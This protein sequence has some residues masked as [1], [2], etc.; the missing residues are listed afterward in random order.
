MNGKKSLLK[1]LNKHV[2]LSDVLKMVKQLAP[3]GCV[4]S[5]YRLPTSF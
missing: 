2:A 5:A 4:A 3:E 1:Q